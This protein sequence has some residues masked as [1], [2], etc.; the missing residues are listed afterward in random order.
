MREG[1][2]EPVVTADAKPI[3]RLYLELPPDP[4]AALE[5]ELAKAA[6]QA[7]IGCVLLRTGHEQKVDTERARAIV[8]SVQELGIACL[9]EENASLAASLG[10]DGVHILADAEAYRTARALLGKDASIGAGCGVNRHEAMRLAE[11][12]ADYVAF[13]SGPGGEVPLE[14]SIELI[15]W[16]SEIFVVPCVAW[17]VDCAEDAAKLA[18]AGADFVAMSGRT[19]L[20]EGAGAAAAFGLA[21]RQA[22]RAA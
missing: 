12:G 2:A 7:D 14:Q 3:C 5:A 4:S 13:G 21:I 22:R 16:W 18:S 6:S 11:M 19:W 1:A 15:A 8:A 10:A 9:V 17:N 20:A